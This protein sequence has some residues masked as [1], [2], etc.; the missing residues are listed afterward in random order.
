M[1]RLAVF[2]VALL[3]LTAHAEKTSAFRIGPAAGLAFASAS[4]EP[5]SSTGSRTGFTG[6]VTADLFIGGL[7]YLQMDVLYYQAGYT[8]A[9]LG[10]EATIKY[11]AIKIPIVGKARIPLGEGKV[12]I[13]AL[14]G[15]SV[16]FRTG[17]SSVVGTTTTDLS[18]LTQ[19]TLFAIEFGAGAEFELSP[20]MHLF[21][22]GRYTLGMSNASTLAGASAKQ[23][24]VWILSGVRFGL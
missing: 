12:A 17:A 11:D 9:I 4:L 20:A 8:Q 14:F 3:S 1:K 5:A 2:T 21:L 24:D 15:G 22:D 6:G 7:S 16:A 23:R 13:N 19:S 10:T 18:S